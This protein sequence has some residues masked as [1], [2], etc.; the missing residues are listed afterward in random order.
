MTAIIIPANIV[1]VAVEDASLDLI[2]FEHALAVLR[3][4]QRAGKLTGY[5]EAALEAN[6][7]IA[8]AGMV[9][10]LGRRIVLPQFTV[11]QPTSD[12]KR[13]WD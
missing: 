5:V 3:D 8:G 12:R 4:R 10:P 2:C 6:P 9:L 1:T 13:L 7:G 11:V